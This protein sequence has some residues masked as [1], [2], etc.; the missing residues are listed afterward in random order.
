M[1]ERKK[2][3]SHNE[4]TPPYSEYSSPDGQ[5]SI[6]LGR[7]RAKS[8]ISGKSFATSNTS[9]S[10]FP[11]KL[12]LK[13]RLFG[14]KSKTPKVH[15]LVNEGDITKITAKLLKKKT[16]VNKID[17]SSRTALHHAAMKGAADIISILCEVS[18]EK[19]KKEATKDAIALNPQDFEGRTPLMLVGARHLKIH[20]KSYFH[21]GNYKGPYHGCNASYE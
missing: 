6:M 7:Q 13:E 21:K 9:N 15:L 2:T 3:Q 14:K 12:T 19:Q 5:M 18:R 1:L 16:N 10:T 17:E 20:S 4:H 11:K 8:S